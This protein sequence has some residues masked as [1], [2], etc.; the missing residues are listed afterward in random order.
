M[1][2]FGV[3]VVRADPPL[4]SWAI[5][6]PRVKLPLESSSEDP[7]RVPDAEAALR[8]LITVPPSLLLAIEVAVLPTRA[9]YF[10]PNVLVSGLP[11][12]PDD[13]TDPRCP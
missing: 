2:P 7:P 8:S 5:A 13:P 6:E 12:F 4:A 9:S 3:V 10:S 11:E 1:R